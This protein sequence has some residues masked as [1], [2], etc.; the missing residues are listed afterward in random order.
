MDYKVKN[1]KSQELKD[2]LLEKM[3]WSIINQDKERGKS[4]EY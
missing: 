2:E 4:Y 3:A 1:H